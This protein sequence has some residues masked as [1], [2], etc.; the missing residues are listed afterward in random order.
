[1]SNSIQN[2]WNDLTK[3]QQIIFVMI[4]VLLLV[5]LMFNF[6]GNGNGRSY[7]ATCPHS[8]EVPGYITS[9]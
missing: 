4:V 3:N 5:A 9:F 7:R 2:W 1:M 6:N 8:Q